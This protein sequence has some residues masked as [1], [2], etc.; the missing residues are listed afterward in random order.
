MIGI[1][2]RIDFLISA[3]LDVYHD[4]DLKLRQ[5]MDNARSL[6]ASHV[7]VAGH[8]MTS[9]LTTAT[10]DTSILELVKLLS[11]EGLHQIP[12]L[13]NNQQLTGLVTQSDLIAAVY[14]M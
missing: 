3:D 2:T 8:L 7:Q 4:F 9:A 13:N 6:S 1:V 10:E 14:R 11:D 12:T 5:L